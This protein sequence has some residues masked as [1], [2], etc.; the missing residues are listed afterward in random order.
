M[1]ENGFYVICALAGRDAKESTQADGGE[2][3]EPALGLV[4]SRAQD[5]Y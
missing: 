5:A 4:I 2:K 1:T 3:G